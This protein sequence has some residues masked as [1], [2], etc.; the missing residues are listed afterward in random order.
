MK[1]NLPIENIHQKSFNFHQSLIN[2][3]SFVAV[4]LSFVDCVVA[5]WRNTTA[6]QFHGTLLEKWISLPAAHWTAVLQLA[7]LYTIP[8]PMST[9]SNLFN[10]QQIQ[11][12]IELVV[13]FKLFLSI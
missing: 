10:I 1:H 6:V 11:I 12:Y 4:G 13:N 2:L 8:V 5:G 9:R 7:Q 3:P